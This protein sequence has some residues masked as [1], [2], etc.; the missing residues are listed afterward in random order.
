M[1][2][3]EEITPEQDF[4]AFLSGI[5]TPLKAMN[6]NYFYEMFKYIWANPKGLSAQ[7]CFDLM[8]TDG[9]TFLGVAQKMGEIMG[10]LQEE[11]NL[12][13]PECYTLRPNED[14]SVTVVQNG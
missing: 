1:G 4:T 12:A 9:A 10:M 13:T 2:L 6:K 14:G 11:F 5:M 3:F 7:Q 8:G